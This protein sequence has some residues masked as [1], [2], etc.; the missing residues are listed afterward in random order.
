MDAGNG[1][2]NFKDIETTLALLFSNREQFG[3]HALI[4]CGLGHEINNTPR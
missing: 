3:R 4:Q 1:K 2:E